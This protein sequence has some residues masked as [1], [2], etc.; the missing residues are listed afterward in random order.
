MHSYD[1]DCCCCPI[2]FIHDWVNW[3]RQFK[4][5]HSGR[6][7]DLRTKWKITIFFLF[8]LYQIYWSFIY[9]N[10]SQCTFKSYPFNLNLRSCSSLSCSC[11]TI[12]NSIAINYLNAKLSNL[13]SKALYHS[14]VLLRL[15]PLVEMVL[16]NQFWS[17]TATTFGI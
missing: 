12:N 14:C 17:K 6:T 10:R 5:I 9:V 2:A 16:T 11:L 1:Y 3:I 7:F 8:S 4:S 15:F 13:L